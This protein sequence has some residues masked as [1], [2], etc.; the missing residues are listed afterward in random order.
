MHSVQQFYDKDM[1]LRVEISEHLI[2]ILEDQRNNGSIF[3]DE[4]AFYVSR[5]MNKHNYRTWAAAN[6]FT[7]VEAAMN[8]PKVNVR[9]TMSNKQII[10]P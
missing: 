5:V 7:M 10:G 6:P 2:P 9:C 4:P 1:N 3:S 8:S